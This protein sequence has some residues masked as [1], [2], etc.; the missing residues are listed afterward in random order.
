[1]ACDWSKA[2]SWTFE[3]LDRLAF[4]AVNLAQ[5]V[6]EAGGTA[7]AVFN[8]ANETAVDAFHDGALPFTGIVETVARVVAVHLD[9]T[10]A[11]PGAKFVSS[12]SASVQDVLAAETWARAYARSVIGN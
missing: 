12:V 4:P 1:M 6:G 10:L 8:A 5:H 11:E 3:P 9:G 2:T 7:P